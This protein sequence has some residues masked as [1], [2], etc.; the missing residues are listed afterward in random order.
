MSTFPPLFWLQKACARVDVLLDLINTDADVVK[1]AVGKQRVICSMVWRKRN[2]LAD[3]SWKPRTWAAVIASV[4]RF[5]VITVERRV[6]ENQRASK[7]AMAGDMVYGY[8]LPLTEYG[9]ECS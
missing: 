5:E 8:F 7:L 6:A 4:R 2:G 3:D 9:L 1:P